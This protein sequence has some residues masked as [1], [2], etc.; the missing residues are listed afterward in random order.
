MRRRA[1]AIISTGTPSWTT[2]RPSGAGGVCADHS[3]PPQPMPIPRIHSITPRCTI[4]GGRI[5]IHGTDFAVGARLPE[6]RVGSDVARVVFASR[7]ELGAI[8]ITSE[9]GE[10]AVRVEGVE[11]G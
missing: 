8:V 11:V 5:A 6:V 10:L 7:T 4:T 1:G 3:A 2:L 9:S